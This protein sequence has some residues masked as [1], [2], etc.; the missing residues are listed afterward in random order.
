MQSVVP[1]RHRPVRKFFI[2]TRHF[3]LAI[4]FL[5]VIS[6]VP[7]DRGSA[8]R[9]ERRAPDAEQ[10]FAAKA[11]KLT[12]IVRRTALAEKFF[13]GEGRGRSSRWERLSRRAVFKRHKSGR[14]AISL[15]VSL[16]DADAG[17]LH[18]AGFKLGALVG[19][20]ATVET[21]VERLPELA[22]L[23]SVRKIETATYSRP[24]NDLA[25]QGVKIDDASGNQQV[26]QDG[27]GSV[28]G[29]IDSG[30]DFRHLD[31]TVPGSN[32]KKTRIKFLLDMTVYNS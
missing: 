11:D 24:T 8:A 26:A 25:R 13:D 27:T 15:L 21:A 7:L 17:E 28:V 22:S 29:V 12:K 14:T 1:C 3:V 10:A 23:A 18:R 32:G 20:I 5:L 31:F 30:I 4:S 16:R 2:A 9:Q 6:G 19:N